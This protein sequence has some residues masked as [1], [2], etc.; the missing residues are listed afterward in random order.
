MPSAKSF[1]R[2]APALLATVAV[3][4]FAPTAVTASPGATPQ[5]HVTW[6]LLHLAH[7]WESE[8]EDGL[9]LPSYGT[10][11]TG[12]VFLAGE[13]TPYGSIGGG[14]PAPYIA[15]LPKGL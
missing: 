2:Y 11:G 13:A 6:H 14:H 5:S 12:V 3:L 1:A 4:A 9:R 15:I 10:N 7:Q 8:P